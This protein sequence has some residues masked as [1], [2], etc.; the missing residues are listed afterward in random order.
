MEARGDGEGGKGGGAGEE[1]WSR[2]MVIKS[3]DREFQN[4]YTPT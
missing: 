3:K 4:V 1:I 2:K